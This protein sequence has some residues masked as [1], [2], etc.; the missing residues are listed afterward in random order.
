[1]KFANGLAVLAVTAALVAVP[2]APSVA[3]PAPA[4]PTAAVA[5]QLGSIWNFRDVAGS[6]VVLADGTTMTTGWVYRSGRLSGLSSS[7]TAT[8]ADLG[9]TDIYDLRTAGAAR[10]APDPA[11]PGATRHLIDVFA[12]HHKGFTGSST[13][14]ARAFMRGMN[15]AFVTSSA[16]RKRIAKVLTAIANANTPVLLH[17]TEGKDRTGWVSAMLLKVAGADRKT[18]VDQY[19]LSNTYRK[20]LIADRVAAALAA[21]GSRKAAIV[22]ELETLRSSYLEAGLNKAATK[23]GSLTR[24]LTRGLKLSSATIAKLRAHLRQQH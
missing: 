24:Y 18:I 14:A 5:P 21:H 17:C 20:Q 4:A 23:Y 11:I 19:L 6:G 9:I 15:T 7:D 3:Q 8:L 16:Q 13:K 22:S 1:V 10:S 12:G 2:A